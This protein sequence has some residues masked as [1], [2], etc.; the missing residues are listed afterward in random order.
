MLGGGEE[1]EDV[2]ERGQ[3]YKVG[4]REENLDNGLFGNT[5]AKF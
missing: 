2:D 3:E 5:L 4:G 1:E